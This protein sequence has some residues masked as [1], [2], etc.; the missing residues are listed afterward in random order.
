LTGFQYVDWHFDGPDI[1]YLVRTAWR[2]AAN[3][4]DANR[5]TFHVLEGFREHL[6]QIPDAG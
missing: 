4:H 5:I 3:F 6:A 2:G 1:I